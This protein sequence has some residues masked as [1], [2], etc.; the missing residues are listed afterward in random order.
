VLVEKQKGTM[1]LVAVDQRALGLRMLPGLSLADARARVPTLEVFDFDPVSDQAWLERIADGCDRYTPMVAIDGAD[2]LLLDI[3]GCA[4]L[5]GGEAALVE[6]VV[7]RL[8]RLGMEVRTALAATPDAAHALALHGGEE[9]AIGALPVAALRLSPEETVALRRAGLKRIDD[10]TA[11]PSAPLAARFGEAAP[12]RLARLAHG[13][14]IRITPRRPAADLVVERRFA[15]PIDQTEAALQAI[16]ELAG[17][18]ARQMADGYQGGRRFEAMLFRTDGLVRSLR[19]ETGLP[20]RN[21]RLLMRLFGER[22]E[23]LS[24]PIDPGFGFDL[25]RLSVPLLEAL[26]PVQLPLEGGALAEGE[27]AALIDRLSTRLGRG[28]VRRL[29]ARDT[30]CPEQAELALPAVEAADRGTW[31]M[32]EAGEPPLRPIHLFDP[33]QPIEVMASVPDGPPRR[34]NWRRVAHEVIRYEGPE[35]IG[36]SWWRRADNKGLTRDYYRVEDREGR[37]FWIF[38]YGLYDELTDPGW[39]LHGLFA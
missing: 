15:E 23:G 8:T 19:I 17:R 26:T 25:V 12:D 32:P 2:G 10:L 4:H 16:E 39:Y 11:R 34:F 6:D 38:R 9:G 31:P 37:R 36:A 20:S 5:F 18:A 1:R 24:D 33:P 21:V 28:R 7:A 30:H 14:D 22:I 13:R 3:S 27:L 35:R 29:V